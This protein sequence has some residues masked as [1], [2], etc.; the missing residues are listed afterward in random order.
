MK[1]KKRITDTSKNPQKQ[2][3]SGLNPKAIEFQEAQ[4]QEELMES[5]QLPRKESRYAPETACDIY[6][7]LGIEVLNQEGDPADALFVDVK[8]PEGWH[9]QPTEHSMWSELKDDKGGVRAT[10]FYKAAFYDRDAFITFQTR[11]IATQEYTDMKGGKS[12][13]PKFYCI[14]DQLT[15]TILYKTKTTK[16]YEDEKLRRASISWMKDKFPDHNSITAYW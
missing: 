3:L 16:D 14:K 8:L 4:G 10:I 7:Q 1:E 9:I 2:W 12:P 11:Y 13:Y 15:D 6:K 5:T